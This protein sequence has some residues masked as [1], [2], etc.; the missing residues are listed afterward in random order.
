[1]QGYPRL[2]LICLQERAVVKDSPDSKLL[3]H[4]EDFLWLEVLAHGWSQTN[5]SPG[6]LALT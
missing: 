2:R 6:K 1:M 3:L 5:L 4:H